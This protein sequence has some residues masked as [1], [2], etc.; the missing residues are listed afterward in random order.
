M[1]VPDDLLDIDS[2]DLVKIR[3]FYRELIKVNDKD[4]RGWEVVSSVTLG[5][6]SFNEYMLWKDLRDYR[7]TILD[8]QIV[9]GLASNQ[10]K[11]DCSPIS[12]TVSNEILLTDSA[13]GSQI[14]AINAALDGRSFVLQ[15]PPGTGKSQ[16]I[17]NIITNLLYH[18]KT[19][20]FVAEKETALNVV[21]E[22]LKSINLGRFCLELHSKKTDK[23]DFLKQLSNNLIDDTCRRQMMLTSSYET[24]KEDFKK[25]KDLLYSDSYFGLNLRELIGRYSF[26]DCSEN[27]IAESQIDI[28]NLPVGFDNILHRILE[29]L[30][31]D[32]NGLNIDSFPLSDSTLEA[33]E[34][35]IIDDARGLIKELQNYLKTIDSDIESS[36]SNIK[37]DTI[38]DMTSS[39]RMLSGYNASCNEIINQF[40][41]NTKFIEKR[42]STSVA[43][44]EKTL[45]NR[46]YDSFLKVDDILVSD[47]DSSKEQFIETIREFDKLEETMMYDPYELWSADSLIKSGM[48]ISE[49]DAAL[50]RMN[51]NP[52][53][54]FQYDISEYRTISVLLESVKNA[55]SVLIR[56]G[57]SCDE[58]VDS[59]A[60]E[61]IVSSRSL[62]SNEIP[63]DYNNLFKNVENPG[64]M[65]STAF[66]N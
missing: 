60:L 5:C 34:P 20:L 62:F 1:V 4:M 30:N 11:L 8:N 45:L 17:T 28:K 41:E 40:I 31:T 46:C 44:N 50:G 53:V 37:N 10:L 21:Y 6:F 64:W 32:L 51:P 14:T 33:I 61:S 16:T 39:F 9:E 2:V 12:K 7:E 3:K 57:I 48:K 38:E 24:D 63:D 59:K 15:G 27:R 19:V 36:L 26:I 49:L 25:Y 42:E 56:S 43:D 54:S 13:D 58:A 22:R 66:L 35:G 47:D 23:G 29:G 52:D 65:S 18:N 55:V